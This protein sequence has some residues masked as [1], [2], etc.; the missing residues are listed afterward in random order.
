MYLK[1]V[2][3][4]FGLHYLGSY[5][6]NTKVLNILPTPRTDIVA[7]MSCYKTES[8]LNLFNHP[9][10]RK[11]AVAYAKKVWKLI[12]GKYGGMQ[13]PGGGTV[14]S[15]FIG[16]VETE[17]KDIIEDIKTEGEPPLFFMG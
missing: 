17:I 6:S 10:V 13:L 7:L 3:E 14:T 8:L 15:D 2:D 1:T 9:L 16:D 5:N 4:M 12:T 11:L